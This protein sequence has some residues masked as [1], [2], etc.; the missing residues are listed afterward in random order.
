M[1]PDSKRLVQASHRDA[2]DDERHED[3]RH[4]SCDDRHEVIFEQKFALKE[5]GVLVPGVDEVRTP[6]ID[7]KSITL[8]FYLSS[9]I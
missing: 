3:E 2:R 5:E 6:D 1:E 7:L 4:D 9:P 8:T